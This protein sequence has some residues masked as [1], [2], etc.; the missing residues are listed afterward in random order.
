[1]LS[2]RGALSRTAEQTACAAIDAALSAVCGG[3]VVAPRI[4]SNNPYAK[5]NYTP[6]L[7]QEAIAAASTAAPPLAPAAAPITA[8]VDPTDKAKKDAARAVKKRLLKAFSACSADSMEFAGIDEG[9]L[10]LFI[11]ECFGGSADAAVVHEAFLAAR[12]ATRTTLDLERFEVAV[13]HIAQGQAS[14]Y[15]DIVNGWRGGAD[16]GGKSR[17]DPGAAQL[18]E[19]EAVREIGREEIASWDEARY[20]GWAASPSP[21]PQPV[22][23]GTNG[24][25][26]FLSIEQP[27]GVMRVWKKAFIS[28]LPA[29]AALAVYKVVAM[30]DIAENPSRKCLLQ[31]CVLG[32]ANVSGK[33]ASFSVSCV[34][35]V[36][37]SAGS[38]E[39]KPLQLNVQA[40]DAAS[41]LGWLKAL[42]RF[43][44]MTPLEAGIAAAAAA[45]SAAAVAS[46][47]STAQSGTLPSMFKNLAGD[48]GGASAAPGGSGLTAPGQAE[49]A[50]GATAE[51]VETDAKTAY[52]VAM[53]AKAAA[54][55]STAAASEEGT[56]PLSALQKAP[57]PDG[58][59][60]ATREMY[61]G[62]AEFEAL[63]G[64]DK[65][66]FAALPG[67]KKT[68]AKKKHGLF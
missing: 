51:A 37:S 8:A 21:A 62:I 65:T 41:K 48:T 9:G 47:E 5:E 45:A 42:G 46:A 17:A 67:W 53:A 57:F 15:E 61:L 40:R 55:G 56:F 60:E 13:R 3:A 43:A 4:P 44:A 2:A 20:R 28:L 68:A 24:A 10:L 38:V 19:G 14:S 59:S 58:V 52:G 33:P 25:A 7:S 23:P 29:E 66:A 31:G 18:R 12:I 32:E 34:E 39:L 50:R 35:A 36:W 63:F 11:K 54:P 1:M 64:M 22:N 49:T 6:V 16:V 27:A 30:P 26:G